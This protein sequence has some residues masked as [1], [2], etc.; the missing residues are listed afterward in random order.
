MSGSDEEAFIRL[1]NVR[2]VFRSRREEFVA[3]SDATFDIGSSSTISSIISV[4]TSISWRFS[5]RCR[6]SG[7]TS[8]P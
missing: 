2:K 4:R 8:N 5:R 1:R 3:V 6:Q 7:A